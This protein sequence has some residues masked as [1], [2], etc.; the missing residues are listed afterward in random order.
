MNIYPWSARCFRDGRRYGV[1]VGFYLEN[2]AQL[3][4]YG[5]VITR[6]QRLDGCQFASHAS[7]LQ[8]PCQQPG[9]EMCDDL[10]GEVVPELIEGSDLHS[11]DRQVEL[12]HLRHQDHP[13]SQVRDTDSR[14]ER[15]GNTEPAAV[16]PGVGGLGAAVR[17]AEGSS[18]RC[19]RSRRAAPAGNSSPIPT[20]SRPMALRGS[21]RSSSPPPLPHV[22][23]H[24]I[25][26][27]CIP[28]RT[29]PPVMSSHH[30]TGSRTRHSSPGSGQSRFP[31]SSSCPFP[32]A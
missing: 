8:P 12:D 22:P 6:R 30:P 14:C 11:I 25:Q 26:T 32:L 19:K 31:T 16:V 15:S 21:S 4:E 29:N 20:H 17:G 23:V 13:F 18:V 5:G 9:A 24:V 7:R 28:P 10:G 1:V 2:P 27:E 3:L